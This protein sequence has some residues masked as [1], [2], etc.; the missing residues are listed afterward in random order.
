MSYTVHFAGLATFIEQN[1]GFLVALPDGRAAKHPDNGAALP[2]HDAYIIVEANQITS[3]NWPA[4]V[5]DG[6]LWFRIDPGA[7]LTFP[8]ANVTG[9][10]D[11]SHYATLTYK[12]SVLDPK[13][14]VK[15]KKKPKGTLATA[16]ILQGTL[17]LYRIPGGE[18]VV[19]QLDVQTYPPQTEFFKVKSDNGTNVRFIQFPIEAELVVANTSAGGIG[20]KEDL[21]IYYQMNEGGQPVSGTVPAPKNALVS[22]SRHPY[23]QRNR[24]LHV[25][26]SPVNLP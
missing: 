1:P 13:Y 12:W 18:A 15:D 16:D 26:C 17:R 11:T 14:V 21:F 9:Q 19:A 8:F 5:K 22:N 4:D 20:A 3:D 7:K 10:L 24:D 6:L 25:S 23:I 2:R